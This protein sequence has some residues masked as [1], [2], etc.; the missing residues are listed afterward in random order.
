MTIT[1]KGVFFDLCILQREIIDEIYHILD[2]V[3][4]EARR[5]PTL[6]EPIIFE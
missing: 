4:I 3:R 6:L 2:N 5:Q 1:N